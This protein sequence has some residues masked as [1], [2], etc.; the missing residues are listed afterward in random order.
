MLHQY[1]KKCFK[2]FFK[3]KICMFQNDAIF[4]NGKWTPVLSLVNGRRTAVHCCFMERERELVRQFQKRTRTERR[5]IFSRTG[6]PMPSGPENPYP[7]FR[8]YGKAPYIL[9]TYP[10]IKYIIYSLHMQRCSLRQSRV[11]FKVLSAFRL[12]SN[13]ILRDAKLSRILCK[14]NVR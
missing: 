11:F 13:P 6:Q 1:N 9:H 10:L 5:S 2:L 7:P 8:P 14:K 3:Y 4:M 12:T